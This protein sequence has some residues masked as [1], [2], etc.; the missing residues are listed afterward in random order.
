MTLE[1]WIKSVIEKQPVFDSKDEAIQAAIQ[2][3]KTNACE[4]WQEPNGGKYVVAKPE[5]FEALYRGKYKKVLDA[6]EIADIERGDTDEIEE[7]E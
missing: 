6:I 3:N 4:I 2:A 5:A 7:E 1:Q